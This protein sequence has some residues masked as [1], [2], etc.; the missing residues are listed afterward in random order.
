LNQPTNVGFSF[1][2]S[3]RSGPVCKSVCKCV[4]DRACSG[5]SRIATASARSPG[6]RCA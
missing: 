4:T 1:S 5:R 2:S 6:R 3:A